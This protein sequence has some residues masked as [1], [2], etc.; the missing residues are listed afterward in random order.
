MTHKQE[1]SEDVGREGLIEKTKQNKTNSN[2][3]KVSMRPCC[4][5]FS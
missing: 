1:V 3:N 5:A 2:N 4:K